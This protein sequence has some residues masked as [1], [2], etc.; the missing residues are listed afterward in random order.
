MNT[1]MTLTLELL[2]LWSNVLC[3]VKVH[4]WFREDTG[5]L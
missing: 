4:Q 2:E 1:E 3:V 5:R